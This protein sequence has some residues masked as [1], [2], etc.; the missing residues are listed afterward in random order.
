MRTNQL[1]VIN[2]VPPPGTSFIH[3]TRYGNHRDTKIRGCI[4]KFPDWLPG[5]RTEND[6]AL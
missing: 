3:F 2:T 6:T 4:Q 1:S 5:A